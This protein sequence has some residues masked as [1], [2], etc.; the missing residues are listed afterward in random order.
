MMQEM[1]RKEKAVYWMIVNLAA[2]G[3]FLVCCVAAGVI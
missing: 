2:V 1:T 3:F